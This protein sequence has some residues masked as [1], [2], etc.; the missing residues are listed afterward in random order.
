MNIAPANAR[1]QLCRAA[2]LMLGIAAGGGAPPLQAEPL[3]R[4]FNAWPGF[5]RRADRDGNTTAW[6]AAGP[7]AFGHPTAD[8]R[9]ATGVRPFYYHTRDEAGHIRSAFVLHPLFSYTADEETYR[10]SLFELVRRWGRHDRAA[11]PDSAFALRR[12]FEVFPFWFSRESG[13]SELSYRALFPVY[14]TIKHKLGFERLSWTL[15]PLYV[16]NERRGAIT[17]ST[18][19]PVVRVTRGAAQGFGIWPLFHRV[20]RPGV[21]RQTHYLW[22]LGF[23]VTRHP[24]PDDPPGTEPRRSFG[25]LPFFA[26]STGPGYVN[27]DYGWPFF[28]YT[29]RI[30]PVPYRE[31]RYFWPLLVQGRGE[32]RYVNRWGPF[33]THSI[34]K[35]LDKKWYAWPVLRRAQWQQEELLRTKTQVLYFLYRSERQESIARPEL[36]AAHLTHVWPL[37]SHWDNAAGRRQWQF[38]SPLE[39]FF[40]GNDQIRETWSPLFTI[41]RHDQR[42][43]GETRTSLLWNAITWHRSVAEERREFHLGPLLSVASDSGRKRIAL[44]AGLLAFQRSSGSGWRMSWL[45]FRSRPASSP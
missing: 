27:Q 45:D 36:P 39:V 42:S 18:P 26:R 15:F 9:W 10:W 44:G 23:D 30:L 2:A 43:P 28:G 7:L 1:V 35:G 22:P 11:A 8:G 13:D 3:E 31:R 33:F 12:E 17:T 37:W 4:E 16:E 21:S 34:S 20:E 6:T 24:H 41:A 38:F 40:P 5:V 19:W 32:E 25:L 29:T 14:G